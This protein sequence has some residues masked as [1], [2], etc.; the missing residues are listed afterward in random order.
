MNTMGE[1]RRT[2]YFRLDTDIMLM[3]ETNDR[4][5]FSKRYYEATGVIDF[6][7][8]CRII[9]IDEWSIVRDRLWDETYDHG[10]ELDA[11]N[12][13]VGGNLE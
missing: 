13:L 11:I 12:L 9:T 3:N 5:M 1:L 6:A 10:K 7:F 8:T 4:L 2:F